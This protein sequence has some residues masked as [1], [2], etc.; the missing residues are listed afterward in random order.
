MAF[1]SLKNVGKTYTSIAGDVK[2][3]TNVTFELLQGEF[4][5]VIG[6][7][8]A[9]KTTLL[10]LLGGMDTL[11]EGDIILDGK[12][13]SKFTKKELTTFRRYDIGFIFQFYKIHGKH[14]FWHADFTNNSHNRF[15]NS[16]YDFFCV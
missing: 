16:F 4:V 8:G 12:N 5:I 1:L 9:G 11:T 15:Y 13:I 7:S 3:L 10:N 14:R 6:Q 2:A